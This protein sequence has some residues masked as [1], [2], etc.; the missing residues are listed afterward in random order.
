MRRRFR[1]R[2][3]ALSAALLDEPFGARFFDAGARSRVRRLNAAA[4]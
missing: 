2:G 4:P 3:G 1:K